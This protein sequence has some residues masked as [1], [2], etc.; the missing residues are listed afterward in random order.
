[1][2]T[3]FVADLLQL[4]VEGRF[5]SPFRLLEAQRREKASGVPYLTLRLRDRTGSVEA[6]WWDCS[7]EDCGRVLLFR[8]AHIDG[9]IKQYHGR[10]EV[11]LAA[12]PAQMD[13]PEDISHYELVAALP[14]PELRQRLAAAIASIR[15]PRLRALLDRVFTDPQFRT[16]F[17]E[18]PGAAGM[19]HACCHGLLQ[20]S[21]EV[22]DLTARM[23]EAQ[24]TW[25]Y[26]TVSHDLAVTGALL[27]DVGKVDE[28]TW[29]EDGGYGLS[30]RGALLGHITIGIQ[31]VNREMNAIAGFPAALK[32]AMMHII[33]A[34]HGRKEWGSPVAPMFPEAQLVHMADLLDT[35]LFYMQEAAAG[36]TE[37]FTAVRKLD[38]QRLWT[39]HQEMLAPMREV[40]SLQTT[41]PFGEAAAGGPNEE[42]TQQ[43]SP[44]P[45]LLRVGLL[46]VF[47]F[48]PAGG[49]LEDNARFRTRRLP[50]VGQAAAGQPMLAEEHVEDY[51]GVEEDGLPSGQDLF[52]LRVRGDSMTGDGICDGAIVLVRRQAHHA[53]GEI[54]VVFLSDWQEAAVKRIGQTP[55]GQVCLLSSNPAHPPLPVDDPACLLV[56]GSV[57]GILSEADESEEEPDLNRRG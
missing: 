54:V 44:G 51:F 26:A 10:K 55:E 35:Q 11:H 5:Q 16:R 46:P 18:A 32:D 9:R 50:L 38:G 21:L 52:L 8:Y 56:H 47:R 7:E 41:H 17:E 15:D 23:A 27:H 13:D 49:P 53:P 45:I 1:M 40:P 29:D 3:H 22:A 39:R 42:V 37:E 4:E 33:T 24:G 25:G 31:R 19:H 57:L 30:R 20:H 28:L 36:A 6:K 14:L 43:G 2:K 34:H 48:R 12:P